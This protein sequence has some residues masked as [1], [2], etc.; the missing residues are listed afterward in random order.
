MFQLAEGEDME[1]VFPGI[2]KWIWQQQTAPNP[3][4]PIRMIQGVRERV[5]YAG[6]VL[7]ELNKDDVRLAVRT[8]M[9]RGA[10]AFVVNLMNRKERRYRLFGLQ[11]NRS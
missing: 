4:S 7:I 3:L 10:E 5:N 6:D 11:R 9:D 2:N 1:K 8:L